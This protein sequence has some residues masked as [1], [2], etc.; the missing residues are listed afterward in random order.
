MKP[1]AGSGPMKFAATFEITEIGGT[2]EVQEAPLF[3]S[4]GLLIYP[5]ENHAG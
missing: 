2:R 1:A 4:T 5:Q 3:S